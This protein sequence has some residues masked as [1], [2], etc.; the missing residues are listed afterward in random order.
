[1]KFTLEEVRERAG[2]RNCWRQS[3]ASGHFD[4]VWR[5]GMAS[6]L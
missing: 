1:V 6:I 2:T 3:R 4:L 5:L